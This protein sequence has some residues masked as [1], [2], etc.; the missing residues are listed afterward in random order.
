MIAPLFHAEG[1]IAALHDDDVPD[2]RC[3]AD[4]IVGIVLER[5]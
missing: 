4:C 2:A 1:K 5:E 3:L